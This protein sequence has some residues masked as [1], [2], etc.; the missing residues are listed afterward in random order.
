MKYFFLTLTKNSR[1]SVSDIGGGLYK[2]LNQ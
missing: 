2:E 1:F